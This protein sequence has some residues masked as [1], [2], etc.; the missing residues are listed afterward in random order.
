MLLCL[1][2]YL[3]PGEAHRI[4][5]KHVVPPQ[6]GVSGTRHVTVVLKPYEDGRASKTREYDESLPLDNGL[7]QYARRREKAGGA[8]TLLFTVT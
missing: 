1:A 5:C 2:L 6:S 8:E 3:R 4:T 7:V